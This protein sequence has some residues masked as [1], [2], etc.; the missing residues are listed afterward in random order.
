MFFLYDVTYQYAAFDVATAKVIVAEVI[1]R[2]LGMLC[3]G[4]NELSFNFKL[5]LQMI[6]SRTFHVHTHATKAFGIMHELRVQEQLC[7]VVLYVSGCKFHAHKVSTF[8][9]KYFF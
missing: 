7:D 9:H 8:Y 6:D 2:Y 1:L 5:L 3:E 4:R